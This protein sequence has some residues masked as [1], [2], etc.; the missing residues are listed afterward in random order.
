MERA[1]LKPLPERAFEFCTWERPRVECDYHVRFK[2]HFYS[3]PYQ[4]IRERLDLRATEMTVEVFHRGRRVASHVRDDTPFGYSTLNEHMPRGH[5]EY[6]EW[7][8]ER[9]IK[10]ARKVGPS[11]AAFID[12]V[13]RHRRHPEHGFKACQGI[14]RL[15]DKYGEDR[16]ERACQRGLRRRTFSYK[17]IAAILRHNLDR[18]VDVEDAPDTPLPTHGNVRGSDYYLN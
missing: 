17:S 3:V 11:T 9:L 10:W 16:L 4:L 12:E 13:M 14:I 8:P 2:D 7:T 15:K 5:K 1:A 6:A 18:Q